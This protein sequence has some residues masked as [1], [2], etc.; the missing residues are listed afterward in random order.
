MKTLLSLPPNLV[1]SFHDITGL[2]RDR[3]LC[4]SDP[5][6]HRIGSGGGTTWLLEQCRCEGKKIIIHAGGESR[7][8]PSYSTSGKILTPIPVFRWKKGQSISQNLLSLQ[9][10]LYES[11]M[12]KAPHNV[13][14]LIASGDVFIRT[15]EQL[16]DVPEADVICYGVWVD[17]SIAR[18]H[19]VFAS[20]RDN[21]NE[22]DFM[23]QKPS[24]ERI[25][26]LSKTHVYMMDIGL[27]LL[28]D[29]A[30]EVLKRHSKDEDGNLRY[31]DLYSDFGRALGKNPEIIDEEINSL[32]VKII[33]LEGGEFYHYGT[34]R[35]LLSST[36]S[37]QNIVNDQNK[38][39]HYKVKPHPAIFTQNCLTEITFT[40]DNSDVWIENSHVNKRW[41]I[42]SRNII[43]GVPR[44]DW[45]LSLKP[46]DCIDIIPI[47]EDKYVAR[48]YDFHDSFKYVKV[49]EGDPF[50]ANVFP[51]TD[52]IGLLGEI[53]DDMLNGRV[54]AH[55][56]IE[57]ISAEDILG[58]AN[59]RRLFAQRESYMRENL[60]MM[61]RNH[62]KSVFY[63]LNLD[64][65]AEKYTRFGIE[66]PGRLPDD[67]D[68]IKRIHNSSLRARI[69]QYRGVDFVADE[70]EAFR[71][72]QEGLTS[73]A[74]HDLQMP[75]CDVYS[76]QIVWSRSPVRIDLGGGWTDT[77]PYCLMEGGAVVNIAIELNGQQPIQVYIKPT[78]ETHIVLRSIDLGAMEVLHTFDDIRDFKK[79][80]S[81]FSI[82]K[83][84][85]ALSGFVPQFCRERYGSLE[86]QLR[87]FGGGME[88]T[89]LSA[90]P[91]GS[92]LGT[93]SVLSA[94]VLAA[95]SDFCH[96]GWDKTTICNKTLILEQLLT[97]G[98]GWQDQYGGICHG[99]KLL[100]T[101]AGFDQT[102]LIRWLPDTIFT[103]DEHHKCHLLYY[104][105]IT[106]TAK[107]ILS[108]IVRKM[109]LNATEHLAL[110]DEMKAHAHTL[111]DTIQQNDFQAYGKMI[112]T[113]WNQNKRLDSGTNPDSVEEILRK[114]DDYCL[115]YKLPGA[116][117]GGFIYMIA[118]DDTAA[119]Q[120]KKILTQNPPNN[121]ARF[122]EM[123]ISKTGLQTTRS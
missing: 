117:G 29:R 36:L 67:E 37:V 65:I 27:W 1:D 5:I 22:L 102:P 72:L 55:D 19:G 41:T 111:F 69:K 10:P 28:S 61:E 110:L 79:V 45:A 47:G 94:T 53:V 34:S 30:I 20:R 66:E 11:I 57:Y 44:N 33:Q 26:E 46:G 15:D 64:D 40:S 91:A 74:L 6:G 23:L 48:P 24:L 118:K 85:L 75:R 42:S 8:L 60:P 3:F 95:I 39:F 9:L 86:Q 123:S 76:D 112:H 101:K 82:P 50:K 58:K 119:A 77:P 13:N 56:D 122:V 16:Q 12:E 17:S 106:R 115:G 63:N 51:I 83:A 78:K 70:A 107:N 103:S 59:L 2:P 96:L 18:N 38:I 62:E 49:K 89:L 109:F 14:T 90:I 32:T 80:G 92:G 25:S 68:I 4:T 104:T 113:T 87:A 120:I 98:G 81:P 35:E 7:R 99:L 21:T 100:E 105:G 114:I 52:D 116:G 97:T 108:E 88:I 43:T 93:S 54:S 73:A 121:K 31:Y 84:A 71:L